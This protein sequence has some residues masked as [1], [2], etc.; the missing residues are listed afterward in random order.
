M[1]Y[2]SSSSPSSQTPPDLESEQ[3]DSEILKYVANTE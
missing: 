3:L 2:R 1:L